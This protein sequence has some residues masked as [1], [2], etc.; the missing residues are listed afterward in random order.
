ML[1]TN[2]IILCIR[3]SLFAIVA[4]RFYESER[5]FQGQLLVQMDQRFKLPKPVIIEQEY[6]KRLAYHGLVI[7]PDIIIH[8][9]FD[10]E[11]HTDR[12][13]G[14]VAVI[15]LKLN[16]TAAEASEDFSSLMLMIDEL[17]YP[18]GVFIN[19]NSTVTHKSSIPRNALGRIVSFAVSLKDD[20]SVVVEER[21]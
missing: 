11:R 21:E 4:P 19:I 3:E 16:S 8:E 17:K 9:P 20:K 12:T 2:D 18:I 5:G 7:R 14:N 10:P 15:E 13:H 6:Q 1:A